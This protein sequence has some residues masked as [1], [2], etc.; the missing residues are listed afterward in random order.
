VYHAHSDSC[1]KTLTYNI[2]SRGSGSGSK[3]WTRCA[4]C[5]TDTGYAVTSYGYYRSGVF[6]ET[7]WIMP[8][9]ACVMEGCDGMTIEKSSG[10]TTGTKS[11]KTLNCSKTGVVESYERDCGK[12]TSTIDSYSLGCGKTTSTV[13]SYSTDCG[14]TT[15]TIDSYS[16]GC[17]KTTST[18]VSYSRNCGKTT[19]TI[20]SYSKNCGK[21]TSTVESY[22]L[23]CTKSTGTNYTLT[24][25]K[26]SGAYYSGS[27]RVYETCSNII[28][29][30]EPLISTQNTEHAR[31]DFS[32]KATYL[33]GHTAIITPTSTTYDSSK[34]YNNETITLSYNGKITN[35]STTGTLTTTITV[36]TK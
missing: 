17:G 10:Q 22:S 11:V 26:T 2:V 7:G 14:K 25:T 21:S 31:L 30:I 34:T 15:S 5:K 24:C 16:L 1:Y 35:A 12:T 32:L 36:T 9:R 29:K 4:T 23:S 27:T 28:T 3:Q 8:S 13:D 19:S 20:E 33:D 18:V 6:I